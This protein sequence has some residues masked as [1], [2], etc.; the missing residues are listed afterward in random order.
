M[1]RLIWKEYRE[2]RLW[3]LPLLASTV[4]LIA[5]RQSYTF[6]GSEFEGWVVLSFIAA[7]LFGAGAYSSEIAKGRADFLYSRRVSWKKVAMAKLLVGLGLILTTLVLAAA[8][9]K[10]L[11]PGPLA[12]FATIDR[13]GLGMVYAILLTVL[14]YLAGVVC[15]VVLPGVF[16]GMIVALA[17]LAAFAVNAQPLASAHQ[18]FSPASMLYGWFLALAFAALVT[19]RFGVTLP[20]ASRLHRY[21]LIAIVVG[22]A[23]GSTLGQTHL[24]DRIASIPPSQYTFLS[25][26]PDG[27][28]ALAQWERLGRIPPSQ[29]GVDSSLESQIPPIPLYLVRLSDGSKVKVGGLS[30]SPRQCYWTDARTAVV[31]D[32][33]AHRVYTVS[34]ASEDGPLGKKATV[35]FLDV[36]EI[37]TSLIIPSPNRHLALG[38]SIDQPRFRGYAFPMTAQPL[39]RLAGEVTRM[40]AEAAAKTSTIQVIDLAGPRFVG[41]PIRNAASFWWQSDDEIRRVGRAGHLHIV[42]VSDLK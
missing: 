12:R 42:K 37:P 20:T 1:L 11:C 31:F 34:A 17:A 8:T 27:Q 33:S 35:R 21:A 38:V 14:P 22:I 6:C 29:S 24:D 2:Q 9:Y 25:L 28:Y 7:L 39:D 26:S 23:L 4:G 30:H 18:L 13:L 5:F 19:V 16:G 10:F 36:G 15:S 40:M 3:L 41:G 32:I